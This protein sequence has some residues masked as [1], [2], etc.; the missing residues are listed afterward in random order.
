MNAQPLFLVDLATAR[1]YTCPKVLGLVLQHRNSRDNRRLTQHVVDEVL[2]RVDAPVSMS[3]ATELV[4]ETIKIAGHRSD[5]GPTAAKTVSG[6]EAD[7]PYG[8]N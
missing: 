7:E 8:P 5:K 2:R 3:Q 4:A 6:A 1:M